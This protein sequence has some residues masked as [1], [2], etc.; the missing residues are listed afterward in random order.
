MAAY[1]LIES[2]GVAQ[3]GTPAGYKE[4][5]GTNSTSRHEPV[6]AI[7]LLLLAVHEFLAIWALVGFVE[8]IWAN[9]PRNRISN[10]LFPGNVLFLQ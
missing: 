1:P 2:E 10:P 3:G 9:P 4:A 6:K 8:W 5:D 7:V